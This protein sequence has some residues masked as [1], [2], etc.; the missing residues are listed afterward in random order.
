[1][2]VFLRIGN[3]NV[4]LQASFILFGLSWSGPDSSGLNNQL[5]CLYTLTETVN[6]KMFFFYVYLRHLIIKTTFG[7]FFFL[8]SLNKKCNVFGF[9]TSNEAFCTNSSPCLVCLPS[10][11]FFYVQDPKAPTPETLIVCTIGE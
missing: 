4:L 11:L 6:D 10:C 2:N 3:T 9:Y 5:A 7:S 8:F 1:M